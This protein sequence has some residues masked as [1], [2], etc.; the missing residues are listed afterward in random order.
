[1]AKHKIL[2]VDDSEINRALLTDMLEDNFDIFEA[3]DGTEA[4]SMILAG[5]HDF[6]VMLLDIMMPKMDGFELLEI[7][8]QKKWIQDIP[9]IMISSEKG[10]SSMERAYDLGALDFIDRPFN[11]RIVKRRI[12]S[13]IMLSARQKELS[14]FAA[15]QIYEKAKDNMLMIN[16]LSH[17]VEFRNGESGLHV[18]NVSM[19]T[20]MI[21]E[22]LI[23][24]NAAYG[25]SEK[26]VMLICSASALHDIGKIAIPDEI[27]NKPGRFT[28]EEF[29]VMKT[30]SMKGAEMLDEL[31]MWKDEPLVKYAYQ[32][33]RW[34][35]ERWDGKGYPDGI[36]G[37]QIPIAAQVVALADVYD[38]LTSKRC[39]KNAFSHEKAVEMILNGEC[40]AMNPDLLSALS[41]IS[42]DLKNEMMKS[43]H[44]I[45]QEIEIP[46][47]LNEEF[48][49][50]NFDRSH[51]L[52][53][54]LRQQEQ[55]NE[56]IEMLTKNIVFEIDHNSN[57]IIFSETAAKRIGSAETIVH[58][59]KSSGETSLFKDGDFAL[60]LERAKNTTKEEPFAENKYLMKINGQ[61]KWMN[62]ITRSIWSED[63]VSEYQGAVG[64]I[65]ATQ[66]LLEKAIG[67]HDTGKE[68]DASS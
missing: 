65:S 49:I 13:T 62:I 35:H 14:N 25:I 34:H 12:M 52:V 22:H 7:M 40:G 53:E 31:G 23:K 54:R 56:I 57:I 20:K 64:V 28:P 55:K 9:V 33:C 67:L 61:E 29:A 19:I 21:L 51:H 16:I 41:E 4:Y 43:S 27:L 36:A 46:D 18:F 48:R 3:T 10:E 6:S 32:I 60:L 38:A 26:D 66:G 15:S 42:D 39:Y 44:G 58:A 17:I 63:I 47:E 24:K 2:I 1:M 11:E 68:P 50:G 37:E 8:N 30:H 45:Q 59:E 5:K